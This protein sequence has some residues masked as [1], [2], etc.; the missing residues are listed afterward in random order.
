MVQVQIL[1]SRSRIG[2]IMSSFKII[3]SQE[4]F[5]QIYCHVRVEGVNPILSL[6]PKTMY[7]RTMPRMVVMIVLIAKDTQF[8]ILQKSDPCGQTE[9]DF[10]SCF[11]F[12]KLK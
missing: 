11:V 12:E 10:Y 3:A 2:L 8:K 9:L 4:A 7:V 1:G 5:K 6:C